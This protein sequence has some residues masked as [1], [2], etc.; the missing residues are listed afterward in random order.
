[1]PTLEMANLAGAPNH[2]ILTRPDSYD[3]VEY[4]YVAGPPP[5][6]TL[7]LTLEKDGVRVLLRFDGVHELEIA[8]GFPH[9]YAGL[10]ILDV[11]GFGWEHARIRVD[12]FEHGPGIHFWARSVERLAG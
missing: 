3:V 5:W 6:G 4:R 11:S 8:P 9:S 10:E 7:D 1:M 12:C 2:P